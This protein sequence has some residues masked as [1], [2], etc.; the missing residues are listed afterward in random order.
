MI[1]IH[2]IVKRIT[3]VLEEMIAMTDGEPMK[4]V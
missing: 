3:V 1:A 4:N 2:V